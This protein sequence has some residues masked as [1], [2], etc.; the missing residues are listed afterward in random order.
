MR[1]V[2]LQEVLHDA[3]SHTHDVLPVELVRPEEVYVLGKLLD[4][5]EIDG[6]QTTPR[7]KRSAQE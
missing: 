5:L 4:A 6:M 1:R 3:G 2:S 7:T